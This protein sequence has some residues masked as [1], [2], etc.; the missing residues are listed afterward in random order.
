MSSENGNHSANSHVNLNGNGHHTTDSI[1]GHD[2]LWDSLPPAVVEK[3]AQ[4]LDPAL[5]S[6]R[7][8]RGNKSFDYIEGH[9]VIGQANEIFGY[10]GWGYELAGDVSLRRIEKVDTKSG[11]L[12]V[13]FAYSAPVRVTVPGSPSR[14][15]IG[16]HA[17]AEDTSEGH[18]TAVK[19]AVTDGMKRALRSFGDRFGN[20]LYGDQPLTNVRARGQRTQDKAGDASVGN[21]GIRADGA[22]EPGLGNRRNTGQVQQMRERLISLGAQQGFDEAQVRQAVKGQ[23]GKDLDELSA[24]EIKP[25]VERASRKVQQHDAETQVRH[26]EK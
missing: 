23:T 5:V 7:K 18:E 15:D 2:L 10:G 16:F 3:L 21:S 12:K 24:V 8:G 25:L 6:Q 9:T 17:V 20:G 14:T 13:S 4:P 22:G 26:P 1:P 19:G 11:E